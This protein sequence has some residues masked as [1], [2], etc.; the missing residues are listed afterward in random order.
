MRFETL[1]E[2]TCPKGVALLLIKSRQMIQRGGIFCID[3][4]RFT[5]L[6]LRA[7]RLTTVERTGSGVGMCDFAGGVERVG[8]GAI[9]IRS[10]FNKLALA[11]Q[12][13]RKAV[14]RCPVFRRE[15]DRIAL[16]EAC[17]DVLRH[18]IDHGVRIFRV[19][20]P[21]TKPVAFWA[22]V[23]DS[24]RR[25]HPDLV[26]LAEAFT[27]PTMMAKLAEVGFSQSYTY[28]TWRHEAWELRDY[29]TELTQGPLSEYMRPSFWPNTPDILPISLEEKG[30][31]HFL[32]RLSL[33]ATLSSNYGIYGPLFELGLNKAYPGKEEYID[34]EKY[35]IKNWDWE[36]DT[37]TKQLITRV[38][39]IRKENTALQSTWNIT[40]HDTDN[41]QLLC[42]SKMD[43]AKENK[44]LMI[45][46]L[47]PLHTQSGWV[48]VPMHEFGLP[49]N[50]PYVLHDLISD[51]RYSWKGEW[52]YVELRPHE[53]PAHLFRL[54][55]L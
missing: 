13:G 54:E 2:C 17:R 21:H 4:Q 5:Q 30:E 48:K 36:R 40:F 18:W 28:F 16:W 12:E 44:L 50:E 27:A 49:E 38:N 26:F 31:A 6:V 8:D 11:A 32:I 53:M 24:L 14:E 43:E 15:A 46:S 10:G 34:S 1:Q 55:T 22:W 25:D 33:A 9:K 39:Q 7:F 37:K 19:D 52:N 45:V 35:E 51:Q 47:D 41:Q 29:V 23:I 42:Y 20:N 3:G